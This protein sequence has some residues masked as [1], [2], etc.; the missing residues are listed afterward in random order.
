MVSGVAARTGAG[1]RARDRRFALA[2]E[3]NNYHSQA[4][5]AAGWWVGC[6]H[7]PPS[8][9]GG[10]LV[11]CIISQAVWVVAWWVVIIIRGAVWAAG[12]L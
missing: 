11:N 3:H 1:A 2:A 12:W 9:L 10:W 8:G 6:D 7:H 5:R 4:A